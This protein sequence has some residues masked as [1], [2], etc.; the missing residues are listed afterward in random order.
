ME[1]FYVFQLVNKEKCIISVYN[2]SF[3]L[4]KNTITTRILEKLGLFLKI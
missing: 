2:V 4:K 1:M 3:C